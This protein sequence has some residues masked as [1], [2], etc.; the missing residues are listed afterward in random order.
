MVTY[1]GGSEPISNLACANFI[2]DTSLQ[3]DADPFDGEWHGS[4]G[5]SVPGGECPPLAAVHMTIVDSQISGVADEVVEVDADGYRM[6]GTINVSGEIVDGV[7][8]E[9]YMNSWIPVGSFTGAFS[10]TTCS[11]T[12]MDEYG[13]YG[14]FTLEKM[15]QE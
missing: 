2:Y 8:L 5:S 12:W 13:C 14:T 11:G 1:A 6:T 10:G 15:N 3:P 7:L 4:G 9:E